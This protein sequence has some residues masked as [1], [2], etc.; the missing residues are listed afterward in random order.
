M[1]TSRFLWGSLL[2]FGITAAVAAGR[3]NLI[4]DSDIFSDCE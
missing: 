1:H 4:I 3:K 2:C